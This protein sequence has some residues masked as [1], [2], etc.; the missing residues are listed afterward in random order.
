MTP[1]I[2]SFN[3]AHGAA[4]G[5]SAAQPKSISGQLDKRVPEATTAKDNIPEPS[6]FSDDPTLEPAKPVLAALD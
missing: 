6:Q 2:V 3:D 4:V 5:R 1:L